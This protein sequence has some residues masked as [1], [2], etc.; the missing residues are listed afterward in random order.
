MHG[1]PAGVCRAHPTTGF[2]ATVAGRWRDNDV[3]CGKMQGGDGA[4][5]N[6]QS[7]GFGLQ[8]SSFR[9]T[10]GSEKPKQ[11]VDG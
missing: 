10:T 4:L 1:F 9:K 6:E 3:A 8:H 2:E 5:S 7:G 11:T